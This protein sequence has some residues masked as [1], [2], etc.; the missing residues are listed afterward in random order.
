MIFLGVG[1]MV[2]LLIGYLAVLGLSLGMI[3]TLLGSVFALA[4]LYYRWIRQTYVLK[5]IG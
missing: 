5:D 4:A 1:A 3:T 2:S